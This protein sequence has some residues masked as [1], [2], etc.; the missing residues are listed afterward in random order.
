MKVTACNIRGQRCNE[1]KRRECS[2]GVKRLPRLKVR[3]Q[4]VNSC[5]D[6]RDSA[7]GVSL[8]SF[9]ASLLNQSAQVP[10]LAAM[11][12]CLIFGMALAGA[13]AVALAAPENAPS[14]PE[15]PYPDGYRTWQHVSSG[16]LK[17]K[18]APSTAAPGEGELA[19]PHGLISNIYA[20]KEALEGYRTGHFPE[21]AALA[22]DWFVIR[23]QGPL[24]HQGARKSVNVMVRDKRFAETGGW[25][26]EDFDR[27]SRTSRN[28]GAKA[29]QLCFQ[30][31]TAAKDREYVFSELKP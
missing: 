11:K 6:A 16:V 21:G 8:A 15:V 4:P 17:P 28:V 13:L 25:G 30:C 3:E 10:L 26:F 1:F 27:D 2:G 18:D 29:V 14:K 24:L 5:F 31:H 22:V 12:P 23:E 19:A 20:N 9:V 7:S